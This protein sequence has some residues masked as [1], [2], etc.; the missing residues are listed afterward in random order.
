SVPVNSTYT[1][2]ASTDLQTWT[3][4]TTDVTVSG[5]VVFTDTTASN[6]PSRFYRA[7]VLQ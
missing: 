6:Y 5:I 3:S 4:L 7:A 1:I 2:E